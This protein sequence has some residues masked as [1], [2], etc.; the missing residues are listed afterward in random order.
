MF[1]IVLVKSKSRTP[2][3]MA[4][5][6]CSSMST[7]AM[8]TRPFCLAMAFSSRGPRIL[9][10]PHHLQQTHGR[11]QLIQRHCRHFPR[12]PLQIKLYTPSSISKRTWLNPTA[13]NSEPQQRGSQKVIWAQLTWS[14][15]RHK[16][17]GESS[18]T[19]QRSLSHNTCF[20]DRFKEKFHY[21][22]MWLGMGDILHAICMRISSVK[23]VPWLALN[24]HHLFSNGAVFNT[25]SRSS[26]TS[27]AYID[28]YITFDMNAI[29]RSLSVIYGS[30]Y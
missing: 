24:L 11:N 26:Q 6:V 25:R 17:V 15:N 16:P 10:G 12:K 27:Y 4:R 13:V 7:L 21:N 29:L 28:W 23:P 20:T 19:P 1:W 3:S 14:L 5:S 22:V 9:H 30:V 2:Y 8:V 18:N